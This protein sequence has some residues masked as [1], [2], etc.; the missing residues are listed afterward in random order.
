MKKAVIQARTPFSYR[1][2][3]GR[4]A[5][6][7]GYFR[8]VRRCVYTFILFYTTRRRE[9]QNGTGYGVF[10]WGN[11]AQV[12]LW[13]IS[14][15]VGDVSGKTVLDMGCGDGI[16]CQLM[17]E[18]GAEKVRFSYS[19]PTAVFVISVYIIYDL[20]CQEAKNKQNTIFYFFM[21]AAA[22]NVMHNFPYNYTYNCAYYSTY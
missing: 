8:R 15:L 7:M 6:D 1:Y 22:C 13:S 12:D 19:T 20:V 11:M 2:M 5:L 3:S 17:F 4:T 21:V 14:V 18:W 9:W 16:H 10:W